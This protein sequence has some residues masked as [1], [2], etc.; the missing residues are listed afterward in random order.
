MAKKRPV[1]ELLNRLAAAEERFLG[2][3]FLAPLPRAGRVVG[4]RV[5]GVVCRLRVPDDFEGWGIFRPTGPATARLVR[6]ATLAER[7]RYLELL[8]QRRL[9]LCQPLGPHWLA[10]PDHAQSRLVPLRLVEDGQRFEA[11]EARFYG[12][13]YWFEAADGRADPAAAA[14]LREAFRLRT[15]AEQLKRPGLTGA[16]RA[17]YAVAEQLRNEAERDRTEDR[18]RQALAQAGAEL[19]GYLERADGLRVEYEV[20]GE[21][22]VSVVR[23]DDLSVQLAGICLSGEDARFDLQSLVGVLREAQGEGVLRIGGD[24]QGMDEEHYWQ[25]HPP[26]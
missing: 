14:Y 3:E 11:V 26:R 12:L 7:R 4:V 10:L 23:Q 17:S 24:N 25:V 6:P 21:R 19:C 2:G 18:L 5:A 9:I 16:Q 20:A 22:H 13:Q 1:D 15:A 8:P